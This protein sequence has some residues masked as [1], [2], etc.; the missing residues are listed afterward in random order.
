M[1]VPASNERPTSTSALAG[2]APFQE[3]RSNLGSTVFTANIWVKGQEA[4]NTAL[5]KEPYIVGI[6][7]ESDAGH[8][9]GPV[10][11]AAL[12]DLLVGKLTLRLPVLAS[13]IVTIR[14]PGRLTK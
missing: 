4:R 14:G 10:A 7:Q 1:K 2:M 5:R 9:G 8:E 13:E 11:K 12:V 6:G 3:T